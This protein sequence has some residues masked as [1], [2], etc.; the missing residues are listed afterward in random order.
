VRPRRRASRIAAVGETV[1]ATYTELARRTGAVNLGQGFPDDAPEPMV[2]EA[3]RAAAD[4]PQQYAPMRGE[5][6]LLKAISRDVGRALGRELDPFEQVLVTVGATE[7]LFATMQAL[8]DPGD[9][10]L[11]IE[12]YYDAYPYMV[13]MAGG[14]PRA[15]PMR[16]EGERWR[17]DREGLTGAVNHRTRVIVVNT[18]HNPT[19]AVLGED[20]LDAITAVAAA[21]DA[22]L[23]VDEVYEHLAFVPFPRLA[24]RPGAWER[25]L[26]VSS[27]GKSFGITGWKIGWVTGPA[28]LVAA[29]RAAHQWIPFAVATPLQRASATLLDWAEAEGGAPYA[30]VR[31]RLRARRDA[32]LHTLGSVGFATTT[33]DAGYFVVA[34]AA[35]LGHHDGEAL[36]RALPETAG[37]VA[38]PMSAFVRE[39]RDPAYAALLRS[40]FCKGDD[41]IAEAGRRLRAAPRLRLG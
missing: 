17:L 9:E 31:D 33:P 3:L 41:A 37:V 22:V 10:V 14:T 12:P 20:D 35:P 26:S 25:T 18:P 5:S 19:G 27:I 2:L 15:L 23:V 21:V 28:D 30:R 7:A 32:L 11:L 29:V 24:A 1:F 36:A 16:R 34:D 13:G 8:V 4:G 6:R 40:A 38:I 39:P